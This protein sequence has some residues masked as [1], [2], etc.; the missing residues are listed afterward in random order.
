[1]YLKVTY[2]VKYYN[3]VS[4]RMLSLTDVCLLYHKTGFGLVKQKSSLQDEMCDLYRDMIY[5]SNAMQSF[6]VLS[7]I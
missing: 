6:M 3:F 7:E 4:T 2:Y 5:N 1:M